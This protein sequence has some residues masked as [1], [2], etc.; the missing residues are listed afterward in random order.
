MWTL[1]LAAVLA[2]QDGERLVATIPEG[3]EA[4]SAGFSA[5]GKIAAYTARKGDQ[6]WVVASEWKSKPG[7]SPVVHVLL[8]NGKDILYATFGRGSALLHLTDTVLF[9]IPES[10]GWWFPGV[11]TPDGKTVLNYMLNPKT[12]KSAIAINGKLQAFHK[13]T[14]SAPVLSA[15]GK[16]FAFALEQD[17]GHCV[18]VN[19]KPGPTYDWVTAPAISA[20]G[21]VVAYGA[22][23]DDKGLILRGGVK[24]QVQGAVKGVFLSLDGTNVGF[25]RSVEKGNP[26]SGLR[27]VVVDREGPAF[28]SIRPPVFSPD[29]KHVTYRATKADKTW[30]V[31]VDDRTVDAGDIQVDPVFTA[32]GKQV[33]FGVRKGRELW[34]KTLEVK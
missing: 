21:N 11:V 33:G 25:W 24:S 20:D 27:V 2:S 28:Q 29:G 26:K 17:D 12:E 30:C 15:D 6:F 18:V 23:S 22:E 1:L 13:G 4:W 19:D 10:N 34:W 5:D 3:I 14:I 9:E 31:V 7:P 8:P 32:D 16:V